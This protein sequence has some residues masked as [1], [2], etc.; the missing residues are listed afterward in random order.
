MSTY[1]GVANF[2][3][4]VRFF[5]PTLYVRCIV[6]KI[7]PYSFFVTDGL[8]DTRFWVFYMQRHCDNRLR[9]NLKLH[10][11]NSV[12]ILQKLHYKSNKHKNRDFGS[13]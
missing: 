1:M 3:K 12:F 2:Q 4:T 6:E 5:W 10:S 11:D 13:W 9:S 8:I 7:V